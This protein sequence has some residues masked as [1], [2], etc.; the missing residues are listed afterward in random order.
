MKLPYLIKANDPRVK[1]GFDSV[2]TPMDCRVIWEDNY[3]FIVNLLSDIR[4]NDIKE[5]LEG[6]KMLPE[7]IRSRIQEFLDANDNTKLNTK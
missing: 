3:Q 5:K 7:D 1:L 2:P 4:N 6:N